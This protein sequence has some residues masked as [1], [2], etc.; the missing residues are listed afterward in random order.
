M[1]APHQMS[2]PA[3]FFGGAP[4]KV[5]FEKFASA[6]GRRLRLEIEPG[7]FLVA[8]AGAV[9]ARVQDIV[10]TGAREFLK[11]DSGMTEILR[12]NPPTGFVRTGTIPNQQLSRG[13]AVDLD[14]RLA[15]AFGDAPGLGLQLRGEVGPA[16]GAALREVRRWGTEVA[17]VEVMLNNDAVSN[18]IR[19]SKTFQIPSVITTS[20]ES[21]MQ[22]MD[23]ATR[24]AREMV[25]RLTLYMNKVRQAAITR[26]IIEVVSGASAT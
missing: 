5:A 18:L 14:R 22:S 3:V 26:E 6:D 4:V 12:G 25:D 19:K 8:N 11:L 20:R 10:S 7:T 2:A 1:L 13:I 17:K 23:S 21:G 24:N 15:D 16:D 9:L